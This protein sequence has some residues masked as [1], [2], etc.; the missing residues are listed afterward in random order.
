VR[1]DGYALK[2]ARRRRR[3]PEDDADQGR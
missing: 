1:Q 2:H 3:R